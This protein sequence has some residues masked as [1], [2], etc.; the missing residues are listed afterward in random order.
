VCGRV[1]EILRESEKVSVYVCVCEVS[2]K[3]S[4]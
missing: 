3:E 1:D 2:E 4:K